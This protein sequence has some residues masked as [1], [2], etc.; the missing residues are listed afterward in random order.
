[1]A[2]G[3]LSAGWRVWRA[4]GA[5]Q[6]QCGQNQRMTSLR[7]PS[8]SD[9]G[10]FRVS[11]LTPSPEPVAFSLVLLGL[12]RH[13]P[14]SEEEEPFSP[15]CWKPVTAGRQGSRPSADKSLPPGKRQAV[16]PKGK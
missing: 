1:M 8:G 9:Q 11:F 12:L 3:L 7:S 10:L 15:T 5:V 6:S 4:T 14:E 2:A 13:S 16:P